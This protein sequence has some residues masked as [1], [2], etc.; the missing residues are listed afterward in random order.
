M[1][2][3]D[4]QMDASAADSAST[5]PSLGK[6]ATRRGFEPPIGSPAST[7]RDV[8]NR[9]LLIA[10]SGGSDPAIASPE[11]QR[12][13]NCPEWVIRCAHFDGRVLVLTGS[14]GVAIHTC[15]L[16][17]NYFTPFGLYEVAGWKPCYMGVDC[18]GAVA[19]PSPTATPEPFWVEADALAAFYAAEEALLRGDA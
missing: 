5:T 8:E 2:Q 12:E 3:T 18:P 6:L 13:C 17:K 11:N 14:E 16:T 19:I 7:S 4:L 1:K 9:S 10:N 15:R